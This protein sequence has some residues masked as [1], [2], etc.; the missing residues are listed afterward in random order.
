MA[1]LTV[2]DVVIDCHDPERVALFWSELLGRPIGGRIGPYVFLERSGGLRIAF[3][4]V[5]GPRSGKNRLHLDLGSA[6][7]AGERS[8]IESLGGRA[9]PGYEAG[10]F[11]VMADPEGNEF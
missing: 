3:Q 5:T 11:L 6:D 8:R 7:P 1:P 4:Q 9:L 10:G 2:K